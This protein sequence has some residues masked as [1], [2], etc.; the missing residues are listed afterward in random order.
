ML[1][2]TSI[3][4]SE[5][6]WRTTAT[7]EQVSPKPCCH[8]SSG[9]RSLLDYQQTLQQH[10]DT[11]AG[12]P[13]SHRLMCNPGSLAAVDTASAVAVVITQA[14]GCMD[15]EEDLLH[16]AG[17]IY[18]YDT[19]SSPPLNATI[20]VSE[21]GFGVL[22]SASVSPMAHCGCHSQE[23]QYNTLRNTAAPPRTRCLWHCIST[24]VP[25]SCQLQDHIDSKLVEYIWWGSADFG[26][27]A[28]RCILKPPRPA[29][30]RW[31]S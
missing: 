24:Q 15:A 13:S 6:G 10:I 2:R 28:I 12:M 8:I 27:E 29:A 19:G 4:T 11:A 17:K 30:V 21:A 22:T 25:G 1:C 18:L 5:S 16:L 9:F 23:R 26:D 20:M 14:G 7:S 31:C 3:R